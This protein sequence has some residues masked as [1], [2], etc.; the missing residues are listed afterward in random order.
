MSTFLSNALVR[1]VSIYIR[2]TNVNGM[3]RD[4]QLSNLDKN[5]KVNIF[6]SLLSWIAVK[7]SNI[8]MLVVNEK[9]VVFIGFRRDALV[10]SLL[11]SDIWL[12]TPSSITKEVK[13]GSG[14]FGI[15][16]NLILNANVHKLRR[17]LDLN[18]R[19]KFYKEEVQD[20]NEC[21]DRL[22]H[23]ITTVIRDYEIKGEDVEELNP[24]E[25][26]KTNG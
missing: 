12:I 7:N 4:I 20:L 3:T 23:C 21:L 5:L 24:I 19:D 26:N 22:L 9:L 10:A 18:P 16:V 8:L 2:G 11:P 1:C 25:G 15:I 13:T 17:S 14:L 6:E